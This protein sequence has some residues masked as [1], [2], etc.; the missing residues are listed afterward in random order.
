MSTTTGT[1][2]RIDTVHARAICD[3]I[4]DQLRGMLRRQV[5]R[6]LPPRLKE[7]MEHL[8]RLDDQTAPSIVPSLDD[9]TI[10]GRR[11]IT[12][13][14]RSEKTAAPGVETDRAAISSP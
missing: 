12:R 5:S 6:E 1:T 7:L 10:R 9:M 13:P 14:A 4:G 11:P 3:E 8:R 2:L